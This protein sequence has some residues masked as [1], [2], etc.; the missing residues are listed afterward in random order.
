VHVRFQTAL[1]DLGD[2]LRRQSVVEIFG[3]GVGV[4]AAIAAKDL[5]CG[6]TAT[7]HDLTDSPNQVRCELAVFQLGTDLLCLRGFKNVVQVG[8][9]C[10]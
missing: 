8:Q 4:E 1:L 5:G 2:L 6:Q 9:Q 10:S 3:H 7:A